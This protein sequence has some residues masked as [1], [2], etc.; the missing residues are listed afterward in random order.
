MPSGHQVT[1]AIAVSLA[2]SGLPPTK[3]WLDSFASTA[4]LTTPLPALQKTALFRLLATDITTSVQPSTSNTLPSTALDPQVAEQRLPGP[5]VCQILDIEDVGRSRW[6]QIENLE[7]HARGETTKGRE[8]VRVVPGE[9][10]ENGAVPDASA[11]DKSLGPHKLLL[12]DARGTRIYAFE[13]TRIEGLSLTTPIGTK[14]VLRRAT[15]ARGVVLLDP[16]SVELV[17][18]KVDAWDKAWRTGRKDSLRAR[19]GGAED[20]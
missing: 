10:G 1:E 16:S 12:Q 15:I 3:A 14:L 13:M 19:I 5:V 17:G 20:D 11:A 2:Q 8:V 6:S 18:G 4:R 9:L 7:A